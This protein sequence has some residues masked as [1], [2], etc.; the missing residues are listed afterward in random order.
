MKNM[1]NKR[2]LIFLV[3]SIVL[4][5]LIVAVSLLIS[6]RDDDTCTNHVDANKDNR[7]DVCQ[8]IIDRSP[9]NG[10]STT[11]KPN[12]SEPDPEPVDYPTDINNAIKKFNQMFSS[13]LRKQ[14]INNSNFTFS[15]ID[16]TDINVL[17]VSTPT[18]VLVDGSKYIL[19]YANG[20]KQYLWNTEDGLYKVVESNG[21]FISS[22]NPDGFAFDIDYLI[23]MDYYLT[24]KDISYDAE[25]GY[26]IIS[27]D[28]TKKLMLGIA[29]MFNGYLG[30]DIDLVTMLDGLQYKLTFKI[31]D[32]NVVRNASII[33]TQVSDN[34]YR[35][36]LGIYYDYNDGIA[37]V[38]AIYY[39][40]AV[41][42]F[43]V[44]VVMGEDTMEYITVEFSVMPGG[45]NTEETMKLNI[46]TNYKLNETKIEFS[47]DIKAAMRKAKTDY[48]SNKESTT[49]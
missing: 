16:V 14:L 31:D 11:T 22:Y 28:Y 42:R 23:P 12:E 3:M 24:T 6:S 44:F 32:K 20:D 38:S 1:L 18:T 4:L 17:G 30:G 26:F 40:D 37:R 33:G 27:S 25:E 9:A 34:V 8:V 10:S 45:M 21:E 2:T 13:D 29:S 5:A 15:N 41:I 36:V 35:D 46:Y 48:N 43:N 49:P 39:Q 47:E 19:E 7:C